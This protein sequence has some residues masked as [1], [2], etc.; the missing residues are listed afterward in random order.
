MKFR[1]FYCVIMGVGQI[2]RMCSHHHNE[3][4]EHFHPFQN[5]PFVVNF[6][7]QPQLVETT[8]LFSVVT[9]MPFSENAYNN[10]SDFHMN[11]IIK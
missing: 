9:V 4:K 2:H 7:P 1:L 8:D 3:D 10:S 5:L 11:R 6:C